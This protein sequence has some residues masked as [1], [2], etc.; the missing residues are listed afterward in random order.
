[1]CATAMSRIIKYPSST[2]KDSLAQ[3]EFTFRWDGNND[4]LSGQKEDFLSFNN[5]WCRDN[6]DCNKL[7][8][9]VDQNNAPIGN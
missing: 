1:M 7:M 5:S 9:G 3:R 2:K 6:K 4:A 8:G